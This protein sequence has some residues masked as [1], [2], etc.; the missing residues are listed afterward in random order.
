MATTFPGLHAIPRKNRTATAEW[1]RQFNPVFIVGAGRSGSS[2]L[3]RI[4]LTHSSF[5]PRV[6]SLQE[7]H[8]F[9]KLPRAATFNDS[10]PPQLIAFMLYDLAQYRAFLAD[11]RLARLAAVPFV[12]SQRLPGGRES[13][14]I[15]KLSP[16][17][18]IVRTYF[19]RAAAARGVT[20]LVEKTPNHIAYVGELEIAFPGARYLYIHRHPV[21]VYASYRRRGLVNAQRWVNQTVGEFCRSY[22]TLDVASH[23]VRRGTSRIVSYDF[24]RPSDAR[25]VGRDAEN[26]S[27][28]R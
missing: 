22:R 19:R 5:A 12:L 6:S 26:L 7:S 21:D 14:S 24:I 9:D 10:S 27:V 25:T 11:T 1:A 8:L 13:L 28:H 18:Y 4:L 16:N 23:G 17:P 3:Y 20:R 15:W 2:L